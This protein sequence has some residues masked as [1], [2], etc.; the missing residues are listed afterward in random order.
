MKLFKN[1]TVINNNNIKVDLSPAVNKLNNSLVEAYDV[2]T[3]S[4]ISDTEPYVPIKTGN[5]RKKVEV[6]DTPSGREIEYTAPYASNVYY[7]V[8]RVSDDGTQS[9][10]FEGSKSENVNKWVNNVQGCFE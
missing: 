2:L 8:N 1:N 6:H 10:W 3:S 4:V 9:F 7:D 5:L